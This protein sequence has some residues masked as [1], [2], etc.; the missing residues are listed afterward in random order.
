MVVSTQEL[1]RLSWEK[2]QEIS[3]WIL[4]VELY[5]VSQGWDDKKTAALNLTSDKLDVLP[6]LSNDDRDKLEEN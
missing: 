4:R 2:N 1:D 3:R 5:A 6:A